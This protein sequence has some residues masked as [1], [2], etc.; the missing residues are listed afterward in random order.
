MTASLGQKY[1]VANRPFV[2]DIRVNNAPVFR[3]I[4][5]AT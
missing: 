2:F 5:T 1:F 3:G 4:Y